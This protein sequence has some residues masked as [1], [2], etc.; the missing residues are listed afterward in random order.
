MT[1]GRPG[2]WGLWAALA[3][4]AVAFAVGLAVGATVIFSGSETAGGS[5]EVAQEI[6]WLSE[7]AVALATVPGPVPTSAN[8]S[9]P[10]PSLLPAANVALEIGPGTAGHS[11]VAWNLTLRAAPASTEV[12]V[13]VS[14]LNASS[15][16]IVTETVYLE[17]P[18]TLTAGPFVITLYLDLGAGGASL[19]STSLLLQQCT[20]VG[21]CA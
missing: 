19:A 8:T 3:A 20:A 13:A 16:A 18:A 2:R 5:A 17:S 21:V 15:G 10:A 1:G 6:S 11:A 4:G 12:E 14:A 9:A 7:S